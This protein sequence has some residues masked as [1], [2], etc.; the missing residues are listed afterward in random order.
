[1]KKHPHTEEHDEIATD[2]HMEAKFLKSISDTSTKIRQ[3]INDLNEQY[4]S[5][6]QRIHF[7]LKE[8]SK[9]NPNVGDAASL[10]LFTAAFFSNFENINS[11]ELIYF[12]ILPSTI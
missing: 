12:P 7:L 8:F 6:V 5:K 11:F 3:A 9:I 1:M 2:I 4:E 10:F